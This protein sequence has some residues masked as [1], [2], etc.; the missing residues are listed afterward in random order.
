VF[1]PANLSPFP[2]I[3]LGG[4]DGIVARSE[5]ALV[6]SPDLIGFEGANHGM[7]DSAIVKQNKV[8]FLPK[9]R[10]HVNLR[11]GKRR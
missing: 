7:K 3:L 10:T 11:T 8:A 5:V 9:T 2:D 4:T 6:K 1:Q